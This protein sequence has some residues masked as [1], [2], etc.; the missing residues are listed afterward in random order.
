MLLAFAAACGDGTEPRVPTA[1]R[2]DQPAL[3]LDDATTA[4]LRATLYDQH[5]QPFEVLPEGAVLRWSSSDEAVAS[6]DAG[7]TV[8]AKRPGTAHVT[9]SA[10]GVSSRAEVTVR[11]VATALAVGGGDAQTGMVGAAL[12][13]P[14]VA[15]VTDR[16]GSGVA[17]V[18]VQFAV[19]SG[20][21][22]LSV[23]QAVTDAVGH[24]ATAWTLGTAAGANRLEASAPS[25][26]GSL[27]AFSATG[28]AAAPAGITVLDGDG[29][30]GAPGTELPRA[31]AV[32]VSDAFGNPAPAAPVAWQ[33]SAGGGSVSPPSVITDDAG[34]ARATW[35]L[36]SGIG[37]HTVSVG[38]QGTP[39]PA[40][41]LRATAVDNGAPYL[42]AIA[43]ALLAPGATA[44]IAGG[45]FATTPAGN[46]V[47]IDGIA[48]TVTAATATSLTVVLPQRGAF[49]C[50]PQRE[51]AVSV[52][53][54]SQL[55]AAV[56]H[57]LAVTN[58]HP[59][60]VGQSVSLLTADAAECVELPG[61]GRYM[62]SVFNTST[63]L[64][65]VVPFQLRGSDGSGLSAQRVAAPAIARAS[66]APAIAATGVAHAGA[67][68][69]HLRVLEANRALFER[70]GMPPRR[71]AGEIAAQSL[72]GSSVP[73]AGE[74]IALRVPDYASG[75]TCQNFR[76]VTARVVYSGPRAVVLEDTLAPLARQMDDLYR[77]LGQEYEQVMHPI[78]LSNFGNPL[79]FNAQLSNNGRIFMLFTRLVNDFNL[80]GFVSSADFYPRTTCP[81]SDRT[82]IFY[83]QV[84]TSAAAG[85]GAGTR[86]SWMQ[87]MRATTLHEVKHITSFGERIARAGSGGPVWEESWLEESTARVAEE[88]YGRTQFG[89]AQQGNTGYRASVQCELQPGVGAECPGKPMVMWKH[90]SALLDYYAATETLTPLGRGTPTDWSFYASG[91]LLVRWAADQHAGTESAFFRALT[92]ETSL[93]GVANLQARTGRAWPEML[94]EWTLATA[95]DDLPGFAPANTR[96]RHPSWNT[97]DI[98]A[99]LNRSYPTSFPRPFP[100]ATRPVGFGSWVA[101]VPGVRAGSAAFFELS[102]T[103]TGPQALELRGAGGAALPPTLRM[104]IVRVQ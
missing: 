6:V 74:L 49:R 72:T 5:Q 104:A 94:A 75:N 62:V 17:G 64:S 40:A 80:G 24:A 99:G 83:A 88:M 87:F 43:P 31:L 42:T 81:S 65:S 50:E 101:E 60:A 71:P 84:P 63:T 56:R 35:R 57:P 82:E 38:I 52:A 48:A 41:T 61:G 44:T 92:Q 7:G 18:A 1:L 22:S 68:D 34:E 69:A 14:V 3:R 79:A 59:L 30:S 47:R 26:A 21:G 51:V 91:W 78:L 55:P 27:T 33:P 66:A 89:Y 23:A 8:S 36:G 9:A 29:Q 20:G 103:A 96:L 86:D 53:V 77:H 98:F 4:R 32:R 10:A 76:P 67:E 46:T 58:R 37:E 102:G 2:L 12:P 93:R 95:V 73:A 39:G 28:R 90:F 70:L 100:L 11:A 25:L 13:Q 19:T 16:H 85:F 15:R 54:G 97:R 45:N